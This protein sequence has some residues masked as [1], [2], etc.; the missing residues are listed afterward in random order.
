VNFDLFGLL[1]PSVTI[2]CLEVA[3]FSDNITA[4]MS[5]TSS[6]S[7]TN[8]KKIIFWALVLGVPVNLGLI[9]VVMFLK[10]T[11]FIQEYVNLGL[12]LALLWVFWKGRKELMSLEDDEAALIESEAHLELSTKSLV[13]TVLTLQVFSLPF[14]FDSV[15]LA[16]SVSQK[17][18]VIAL[19]IMLSRVVITIMTDTIV[20]FFAARTNLQWG[21]M[22]FIFS[23]GLFDTF[24][25]VE[26]ICAEHKLPHIFPFNVPDLTTEQTIALLVFTVILGLSSWRFIDPGKLN[27]EEINELS[28]IA[29]VDNTEG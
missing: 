15:P 18:T 26:N 17:V 5:Q 14:Y 8:Q 28:A 1:I 23:C 19:G 29:L 7:L 6:H 2:A 24:E 27:V 4:L 21:V 13:I 22:L 12:G 16:S 3:L 10:E 20:E 11:T 9:K 25:A